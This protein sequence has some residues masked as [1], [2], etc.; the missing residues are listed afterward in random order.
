[1]L[2]GVEASAKTREKDKCQ[3]HTSRHPGP[4]IRITAMPALPEP[5]ERA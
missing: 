2:A 4:E 1:M 5:D 3:G